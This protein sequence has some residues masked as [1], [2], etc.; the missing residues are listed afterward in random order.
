MKLAFPASSLSTGSSSSTLGP[1]LREEQNSGVA[2]TKAV[3]LPEAI[4]CRSVILC[5]SQAGFRV[6]MG[7]TPRGLSIVGVSLGIAASPGSF[8]EAWARSFTWIRVVATWR[9]FLVVSTTIV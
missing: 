9:G 4:A 8:V 7:L 6:Q 3:G 2:T 1:Q 5:M